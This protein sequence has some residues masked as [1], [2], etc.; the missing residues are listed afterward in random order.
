[1][2]SIIVCTDLNGG[3]GKDNAIPWHSSEDFKHFKAYTTSKKVLMGYMTWL[4]LPAN[5][6]PLPNRHNIIVTSHALSY[7]DKQYAAENNVQFITKDYL[8][9]FLTMNDNVV[10][11]GGEQI[12]SLAMPYVN[13]IVHS[14]ID[15]NYDCDRFF[16]IDSSSFYIDSF[17]E[18]SDD[19]SVNYWIRKQ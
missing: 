18:I 10:V 9:T 15:K 7:A 12:Y 13:M 11:M 1:M 14:V 3:I 4:S 6:R 8:G 2:N 19:V 5:A 16:K 17:N